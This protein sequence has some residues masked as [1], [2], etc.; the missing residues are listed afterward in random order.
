MTSIVDFG[1]LEN[2]FIIAEVG[3]NHLGDP[4]LA[5]KTLDAAA[6]AGAHA[7]KFQLY[8]P[9]L[10]ITASE[11]VLKHVPNNT[12][13]T[14]RERFR[15]M[16][17]D[18]DDFASLAGHAKERGIMYLCTPFDGESADFLDAHVEAFKIAS[19]DTSNFAL[20]EH[21][22]AKGKPM[23]VSTGL[24][25]QEEVDLLVDRLPH[26]RSLIFHCI[27]SYPTPD[28]DLNLDLIAFYQERYG[29]PV[30]FSDHSPDLVAPLSAIAMGATII[31]KHFIFDKSLPGGDRDLSLDPAGMK[32]LVDGAR[33]IGV[34]RGRTPRQVT[35]SEAY[36]RGKLRR[37]A[38]VN[39][40]IKAGEEFTV[41]EVT[42][43][44]PEE[45]SAYRP[46]DVMS[47]KVLTATCDIAVETPLSPDNCTLG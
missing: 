34:M 13:D 23:L 19:G 32:E 1:N 31:E 30:G 4:E 38:Y 44:R 6:D 35:P 15:H 22:T 37:S 42:Y 28:E 33:R 27:G 2:P 29:I 12:F 14:Q 40:A 45:P 20:I 17:L 11:P 36:G 26:D 3:N 47:A 43:L 39:R 16:V 5:H 18:H 7:V 25:E 46:I 21:V 10:L 8:N 24:C 9:D 41:G